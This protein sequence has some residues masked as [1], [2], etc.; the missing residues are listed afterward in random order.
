MKTKKQNEPKLLG[1]ATAL[2]EK[3]ISTQKKPAEGK[4]VI[5]RPGG[6]CC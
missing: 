2:R 3:L 4:K 6:M 1:S 5:G